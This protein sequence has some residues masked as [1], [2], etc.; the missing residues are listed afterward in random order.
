[1][2]TN[3]VLPAATLQERIY[4]GWIGK[5]IG[6]SLGM[7]YEGV[8]GPLDI[9]LDRADLTPVPNDDLELQLLWLHALEKDGFA[10]ILGSLERAWLDHQKFY[11]DEY[12]VAAHNLRRGMSAPLCGF[13]GN[14][15]GR[16]MG[17]AIRSEIWACQ[18]FLKVE[19]PRAF[20]K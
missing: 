14:W 11:V 8:A 10:D 9:S 12:A 20:R 18:I 5:S 2:M 15:F 3:S 7:P 16:G 19:L 13:H 6:G 4:A 17:A 1:M